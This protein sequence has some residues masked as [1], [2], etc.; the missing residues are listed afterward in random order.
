MRITPLLLVITSGLLFSG[1]AT[2]PKGLDN[3]RDQASREAVSTSQSGTTLINKADNLSRDAQAQETYRFAPVLTKEAATSLKEARTLQNKGRAD[4]QVRVQALAAAATYQRA[5]DQTL[6]AR[7][8]L[9]PSLAHM[10]V[11]NSINSRTYY[12]SDYANVEKQFA[13]IIAT[14]ETTADPASAKQSQRELLM[15]MHTLEVSTVGF[16]QLQTV[17]NQMQNLKNANAATLIPLSYKTATKTLASAED[18]I[19]QNPR[20]S[21]EI[22]HL[23]EQAEVSAAHAQV[24]LSMV[25]ETLDANSDN[26]EALV[27]RTERWLYNIAAALK[28]PDIRHLPMDEQSRQLADGV[29]DL[30]QR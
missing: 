22:A 4:D 1:C 26:A 23:R 6:L 2:T 27:L 3:I 11:L 19:A 13:D 28:F 16:L 29:E 12:P 7:E 9:A 15:D 25:N 18:F 24:I 5:L 14:L 21:G 20:A 8:T 10:E 30:L 17:R